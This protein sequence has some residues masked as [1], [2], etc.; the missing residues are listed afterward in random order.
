MYRRFAIVLVRYSPLR[1]LKVWFLLKFIFYFHFLAQSI[2]FVLFNQAKICVDNMIFFTCLVILCICV[3]L[4]LFIVEDF[5][6]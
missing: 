3:Y 1:S 6:C 2:Y 4:L 5:L